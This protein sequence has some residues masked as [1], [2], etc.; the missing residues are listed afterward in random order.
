[1]VMAAK[2]LERVVLARIRG[3][4]EALAGVAGRVSR[5]ST[6]SC[7][8]GVGGVSSEESAGSDGDVGLFGSVQF[9]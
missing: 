2:V 8:G 7:C 6:R 9:G 5:G 3:D 1:M 4:R